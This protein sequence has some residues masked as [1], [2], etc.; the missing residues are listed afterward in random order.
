M[1]KEGKEVIYDARY[2]D[3]RLPPKD[4]CVKS[5]HQTLGQGQMYAIKKSE[6]FGYCEVAEILQY[7]VGTEPQED[8]VRKWG[9][10]NG[11]EVDVTVDF[12]AEKQ[13][14]IAAAHKK[15]QKLE[16]PD[17]IKFAMAGKENTNMNDVTSADV[18]KATKGKVVTKITPA[19]AKNAG[20]SANG[21]AAK[22]QKS[23]ATKKAGKATKDG[24]KKAATAQKA[25]KAPVGK[26]G[27][28]LASFGCREGTARAGMVTALC[29]SVGK[30]IPVKDI[31]KATYGKADL[32]K[33]SALKMVIKGAE[34][35][36]KL[37]KIDYHIARGEDAKG[38]LT[39]GL[40][41]GKA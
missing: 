12:E 7:N 3:N 21:S 24:H 32:E 13:K 41:K 16:T 18:A 9:Y 2:F 6:E 8:I 4:R 31:L 25:P 28:L 34:E 15:L 1:K 38:D 17:A 22:A 23:G 26:P 33:I 19:A 30:M 27:S 39:L 29:E 35:M 14:W 20:K 11:Q 37:N 36:I 40:K 10:M 5:G